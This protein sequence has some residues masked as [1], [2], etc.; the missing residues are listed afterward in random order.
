MILKWREYSNKPFGFFHILLISVFKYFIPLIILTA[1]CATPAYK[2]IY[3]II[4][5]KN[6]M[7]RFKKLSDLGKKEVSCHDMNEK[8]ADGTYKFKDTLV[9]TKRALREVL[10]KQVDAVL[11]Q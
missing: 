5:A 1:G 6:K 9:I 4:P 10:R 3:E 11:G 2:Y 8:N 7:C